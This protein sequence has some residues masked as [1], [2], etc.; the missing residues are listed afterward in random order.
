MLL[1]E[2]SNDIDI[3]TLTI[4]EDFLTSVFRDDCDHRIP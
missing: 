4:L 2:L 1:D 3:Q